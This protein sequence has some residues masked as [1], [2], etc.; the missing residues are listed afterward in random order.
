MHKTCNNVAFTLLVFTFMNKL[1]IFSSL[2]VSISNNENWDLAA[3]MG[4]AYN[5][6][7]LQSNNIKHTNGLNVPHYSMAARSKAIPSKGFLT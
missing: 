5:T 3:I 6:K 2:L 7:Q 4:T 1:H